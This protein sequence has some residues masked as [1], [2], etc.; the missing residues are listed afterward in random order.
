[1]AGLYY[2]GPVVVMVTGDRFGNEDRRK[3]RT[4]LGW[5]GQSPVRTRKFF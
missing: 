2:C 4:A 3:G 1:M 5:T